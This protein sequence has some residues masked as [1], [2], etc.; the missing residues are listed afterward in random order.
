MVYEF[1]W[2]VGQVMKKLDELGI[3]ENTL[4]IVSSDNG[5]T[6]VSDDGK[7]YGHKICGDLKGHKA[8]L[9]EGGHR[10]PFIVRWPDKVA[11][12]TINNSL[13]SIM[14]IYATAA[15]ILGLPAPEGDG[16]SFLALL[17]DKDAIPAR[18]YMVHHTYSGDFALRNGNWKFI[19]KRSVKD[20]SWSYELY[21]LSN[22]V[23]ETRNLA[24]GM[25]EKTGELKK[26]LFQLIRM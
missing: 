7:D 15:E 9:Y 19:P 14:D 10:I 5:G 6:P 3:A 16:I 21:D 17:K 2:A 22:D 23:N 26:I 20:G 1:D 12:H 25:P 13:V 8:S 24:G 11:P 18:K 4:L